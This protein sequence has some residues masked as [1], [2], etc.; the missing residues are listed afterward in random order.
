MNPGITV[1]I[2]AHPSRVK[3]GMLE[4]A[5]RSIYIQEHPAHAIAVAIDQ[6]RGG[7]SRTRQRALDMV[8]TEWV[9]FLDSDDWFMPQHLAR[10]VAAQRETG[11]DYVYS[12]YQLVVLGHARHISEGDHDGVFPWTH[13]SEPWDPANPRQ[14]T[15]TTMVRTE[16]AQQ[17]GFWAM[18]DAEKFP[19]GHRVGEDYLF[20]LECNRLGRIYH[21]P[22]RTWCWNHHGLNTSGRPGQGDA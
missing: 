19:D 1:A 10:L 20:T 11:A 4:K 21:L 18:D 7:A 15:I 5:L 9:A 16:L 13:F 12:W 3:N 2:P 6:D 14:T 22:E 17:I 8:Q